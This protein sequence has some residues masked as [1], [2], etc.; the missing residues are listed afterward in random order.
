MA[1]GANPPPAKLTARDLL[2]D[3]AVLERAYKEL[4]PGLYRYNTPAQMDAAFAALRQEL[5]HDQT[6]PE[7]YLAISVF[8]AKVRCGHT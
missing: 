3:A 5:G 7:A 2:A 8:L 1:A 4:H 6:L